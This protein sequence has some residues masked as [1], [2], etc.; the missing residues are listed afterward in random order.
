MH[1]LLGVDHLDGRPNHSGPTDRSFAE[2]DGRCPH[3]LEMFWRDAVCGPRVKDF[4]AIVEL[5]D[6]ALI[7]AG[8]LHR[9]AH[10]RLQHS[11][12]IEGR[13]DCLADLAERP[14]LAD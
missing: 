5:V 2:P 10:D 3:R 12:Q 7:A 9:P 14:E 6:D 1:F 4:S 11:A 13:A 8:Q